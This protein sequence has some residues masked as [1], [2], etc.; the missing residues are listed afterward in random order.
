MAAKWVDVLRMRISSAPPAA[1]ALTRPDI[2]FLA[3]TYGTLRI[4]DTGASAPSLPS[5]IFAC[6]APNVLEHYDA[7]F[8]QLS[9]LYRLICLEM[10]GF[11]FSY[12]NAR[13]DFSLRQCVDVVLQALDALRVG[14]STATLMF[15]CAMSY[16]A[17]CVAAARPAAVERVVV[18]Q[19]PCWEEERAW[20]RRIDTQGWIGTPVVGQLFMAA[21]QRRVADAWYEAALPR[22]RGVE[23]F[24][25]PARK[26]LA[27]GGIFCLASLTQTWFRGLVPE[28]AVEQPTVVLWGGSDRTHRRSNPESVL[29]YLKRGTVIRYPEA[30]HFPELED[31]ERFKSL[32]LNEELWKSLRENNTGFELESSAKSDNVAGEGT[33]DDDPKPATLQKQRKPFDSHL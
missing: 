22:G 24:A 6:D 31:P 14:Q 4:R 15:P 3:T 10:P 30:G 8:G 25:G 26:V 23:E 1:Q 16:V 13:F 19:C 17:F 33:K 21:N 7:L 11:G 18:S 28:F 12:P 27:E 9:P 5:I 29:R 32:L 2:S 20:S